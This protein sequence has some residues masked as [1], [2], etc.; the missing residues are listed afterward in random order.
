[1]LVAQVV[2]WDVGQI[3]ELGI[4]MENASSLIEE[5]S[6]GLIGGLQTT[7]Q[8]GGV[9]CRDYMMITLDP[10]KCFHHHAISIASAG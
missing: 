1:M 4:D 10:M 3:A 9:L 2:D 8:V 7:Q 5:T 6:S